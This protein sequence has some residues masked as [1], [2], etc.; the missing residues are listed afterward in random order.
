ME[1]AAVVNFKR[2]TLELSGKCPIIVFPDTESK[3]KIAGVKKLDYMFFLVDAVVE[4]AH[5]AAFMNQGQMCT[6]GAR[7]YVHEDIYDEFVAK[8]VARAQR[9]MVTDPFQLFCEQGPQVLI[10]IFIIYSFI[11]L[12]I[13]SAE[14]NNFLIV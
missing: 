8:S 9:R 3:E 14:Q 13:N 1:R 7:T 5:Q 12:F 10:S 4:Q 6:S 2:L 11:Y